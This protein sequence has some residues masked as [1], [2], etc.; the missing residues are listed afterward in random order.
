MLE[1]DFGTFSYSGMLFN[2]YQLKFKS[3]SEHTIGTGGARF[4]LEIQISAMSEDMK[5][6]TVSILF[7]LSEKDGDFLG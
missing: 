4:P 1:G 7:N 6:S 3:P 5:I 2:A